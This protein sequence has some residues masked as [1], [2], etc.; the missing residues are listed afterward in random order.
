MATTISKQPSVGQFVRQGS[1]EWMAMMDK[2]ARV[3][4]K[5]SVPFAQF[6]YAGSSFYEAVW[7]HVLR[8]PDTV[9][10]AC[11]ETKAICVPASP[12]WSPLCEMEVDLSCVKS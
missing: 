2:A 4:A 12:C 3:A 1:R 7:R 5:A 11:I 9:V 8:G 6:S 10:G